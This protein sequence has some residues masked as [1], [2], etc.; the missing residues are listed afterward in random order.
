MSVIKVTIPY[1]SSDGINHWIT[2]LTQSSEPTILNLNKKTSLMQN[3]NYTIY[4]KF[5]TF[6]NLTVKKVGDELDNNKG[7]IIK[8]HLPDYNENEEY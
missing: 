8:A 1:K 2:T 5:K 6:F 3:I 4:E 7:P